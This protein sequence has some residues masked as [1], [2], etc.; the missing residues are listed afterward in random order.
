MSDTDRITVVEKELENFRNGCS[1]MLKDLEM[2][3]TGFSSKMSADKLLYDGISEKLTAMA[4]LNQSF[5][6]YLRDMDKKTDSTISLL[7]DKGI[8]SDKQEFE[9]LW[10][11]ARGARVRKPTEKV[12]LNDVAWVKYT[13]R[14]DGKIVNDTKEEWPIRIGSGAASFERSL[15]GKK[16]HTKGIIYKTKF[17]DQSFPDL[18]DKMVEFTIDLGKVKTF[19]KE[20]SD[21]NE[22]SNNKD[23]KENSNKEESSKSQDNKENSN[24]ESQDNKE[25][26]RE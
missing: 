19:I 25:V 3:K 17:T 6:V 18:K 4:K 14:V 26:G 9:D 5:L 21:E 8:I 23:N 22:D 24:K 15:L 7:L 2:L 10:D 16:P 13:A 12:Q 11:E 20:K 1:S